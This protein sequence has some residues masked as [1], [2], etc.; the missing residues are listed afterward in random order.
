MILAVFFICFAEQIL[1]L[2]FGERYAS[3]ADLLRILTVG[4]LVCLMTGPCEILLMMAGKQ[5][6]TLRVNVVAAIALAVIGPCAV[7]GF[8]M[9]GLAIAIATVTA[10]QNLANCYLAHRLLGIVTHVGAVPWTT[11]DSLIRRGP[12]N[13]REL[14]SR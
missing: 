2:V 11:L 3:S 12:F 1:T 6:T 7:L 5:N 13:L 14:Y 9:R 4:Q 10:T 8:G